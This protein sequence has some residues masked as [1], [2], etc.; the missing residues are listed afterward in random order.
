VVGRTSDL[1]TSYSDFVHYLE[2]VRR[3]RS[4][5]VLILGDLQVDFRPV[6]FHL[7]VLWCFFG[8][9]GSVGYEELVVRRAVN[10][11]ALYEVPEK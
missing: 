6:Q 1:H 2:M 3:T 8:P 7:W 5:P 11:L 4:L 10:F 9:G